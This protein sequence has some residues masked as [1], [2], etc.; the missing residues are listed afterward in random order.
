[1]IETSDLS[2]KTTRITANLILVLS[3]ISR[4]LTASDSVLGK[5]REQE[6]LAV[7]SKF[8]IEFIQSGGVPAEVFTRLQGYGLMAD[9]PSFDQDPLLEQLG[10]IVISSPPNSP[11]LISASVPFQAKAADQNGEHWKESDFPQTAYQAS[12]L[13][14]ISPPSLDAVLTNLRQQRDSEP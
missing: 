14:T 12:Y 5:K 8:S 6:L 13:F 10:T 7:L 3:S 1:M 4:L 11:L 2:E 9:F